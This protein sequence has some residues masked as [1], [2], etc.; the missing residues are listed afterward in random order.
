MGTQ[1]TLMAE[2]LD[3]EV[4]ME[5]PRYSLHSSFHLGWTHSTIDPTVNTGMQLKVLLFLAHSPSL[6]LSTSLGSNRLEITL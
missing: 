5:Y 1:V 2:G 4:Q 3:D 6:T